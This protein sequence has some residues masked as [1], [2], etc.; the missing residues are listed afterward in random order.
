MVNSTLFVITSISSVFCHTCI[1]WGGDRVIQQGYSKSW[2]HFL[3]GCEMYSG[4]GGQSSLQVLQKRAT[5]PGC[6]NWLAMQPN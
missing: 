4:K 5:D 3:G 1:H 6:E 2:T